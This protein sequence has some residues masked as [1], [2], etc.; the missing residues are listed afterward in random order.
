ME[1]TKLKYDLTGKQVGFLN[2]I[3]PVRIN[4]QL[5]WETMCICGEIRYHLTTDLRKERIKSCGCKRADLVSLSYGFTS[6]VLERKTK[7]CNKCGIEK[8]KEECF[9]RRE[10][11]W[12]GYRNDCIECH[13][14][15]K[16]IYSKNNSQHKRDYMKQY[17]LDKPEVFKNWKIENPGKFK[18]S[19]KNS[20]KKRMKNDPLYRLKNGISRLILQSISKKGYLKKSKTNEI[21]GIDYNG[22]MKHI[23]SQF[24]DG[25][26]WDNR[27]EWHLDHIIPVSLGETEEEIIR[28]NH[29]TNLQ[30]LWGKDNLHKSNTILDEHRHLVEKYIS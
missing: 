14:K 23:E 13:L 15:Q 20:H 25:M 7:V 27:G 22:F 4:G 3:K 10:G 11:V 8:N 26:T 17:R 28:L 16:K 9:Y 2:V 6:E 29:Y 19:R 1:V 30:P 18:E 12:D 24:L 5:K 21:L